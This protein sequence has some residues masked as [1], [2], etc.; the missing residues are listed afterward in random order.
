MKQCHKSKDINV[1]I[2]AASSKPFVL[3][4]VTNGDEA[5]DAGNRGFA[6]MYSQQQCT[7]S[8]LF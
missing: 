2:L 4:V 6:L 7:T 3:T 8:M 5:T 1:N